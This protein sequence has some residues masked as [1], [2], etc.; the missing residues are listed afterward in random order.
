MQRCSEIVAPIILLLRGL[1]NFWSKKEKTSKRDTLWRLDSVNQLKIKC[2]FIVY[3]TDSV[4]N[5][6]DVSS[7]KDGVNWA[8]SVDPFK[9]KVEASPPEIA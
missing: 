3:A 1:V 2:W 8:A 5:A 4:T 7:T 9:A 6:Q